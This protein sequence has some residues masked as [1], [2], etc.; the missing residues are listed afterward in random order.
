MKLVTFAVAAGIFFLSSA[1][2]AGA[3]GPDPF[4]VAVPVFSA[5]PSMNGT[6]DESWT[7]AAHL[8]VIF[9]FTYQRVGEPTTVY[10]AQD[11]GAIDVAFDVTQKAPV[12]ATQETNGPAHSLT[13]TL[14]WS[15]GPRAPAGLRIRFPPTF[16]AL[17]IKRR[18]KTVPTARSGPL[19]ANVQRPDI[20]SRCA[21]R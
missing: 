13:T 4:S 1:G 11:P 10:I 21:F 2:F 15:F 18:V 16:G 9:D 6:I 12:T 5:A 3:D 19:R 20:R 17:D 14:P 7:K 8:P